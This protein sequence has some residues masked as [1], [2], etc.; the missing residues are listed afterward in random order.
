MGLAERSKMNPKLIYSYVSKQCVR[1]QIRAI[2]RAGQLETD[3]TKIAVI[4]NEAKIKSVQIY[5]FS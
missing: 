3:K 2:G 4:F 1:D 5:F